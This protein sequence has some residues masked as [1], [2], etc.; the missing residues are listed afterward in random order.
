MADFFQE[1]KKQVAED[2]IGSKGFTEKRAE[3]IFK[4]I[5]ALLNSI[6]LDFESISAEYVAIENIVTVLIGEQKE[7]KKKKKKSDDEEEE[8]AEEEEKPPLIKVLKNKIKEKLTQTK[9]Y[10]SKVCE[11]ILIIKDNLFK[12]QLSSFMESASEGKSENTELI[13]NIKNREKEKILERFNKIKL[14]KLNELLNQSKID[15]NKYIETR[16]PEFNELYISCFDPNDFEELDFAYYLEELEKQ[17]KEPKDVFIVTKSEPETMS[18]KK[19]L[20]EFYQNY[21]NIY[22]ENQKARDIELFNFLKKYNKKYTKIMNNLVKIGKSLETLKEKSK[23]SA[24]RH[25]QEMREY[26][27]KKK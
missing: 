24:E 14:K 13:N 8:P 27:N 1:I 2:I 21:D 25:S 18:M 19:W 16:K 7:K 5:F 10:L 11:P 15:L 3:R 17:A 26:I 22:T 20:E 12:R 9:S 23:K 6:Y 4:K